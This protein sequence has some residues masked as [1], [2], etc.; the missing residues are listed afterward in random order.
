MSY[1]Y[2]QNICS[3]PLDDKTSWLSPDS[4]DIYPGDGAMRHHGIS[5][6][7]R[8]EWYTVGSSVLYQRYQEIY[9]IKYQSVNTYFWFDH[10]TYLFFYAV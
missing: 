5:S 8:E 7:H 9:C 3:D 10:K 4:G 6:N 1:R 2:L